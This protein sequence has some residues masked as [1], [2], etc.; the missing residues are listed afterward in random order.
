MILSITN[1]SIPENWRRP[2]LALA[3]ALVFLLGLY[4]DTVISITSIWWRS[5][6]YAHGLVIIPLT[7][8]MI[9]IRRQQVAHL[10]PV[11]SWWGVT[12]LLIAE[13]IW[14]LGTIVD[15][16]VVQQLALLGMIWAVIVGILGL[17]AVKSILFPLAYLFFAIPL[18]EGLIPSLMDITA[19]FTVKALVLTGFPVYW[20]GTSFSIPIGSFEV[21]KA[22]SG[23][24]YLF[25]SV[26]LGSLFAY[27]NF[28]SYKK[29]MIFILIS[30]VLPIVANGLRAYGIV[31]IANY[32]NMR[33]AVGLDHLI[34]G[35]LFFGLIMFLLFFFGAMWRDV[36]PSTNVV[37]ENPQLSIKSTKMTMLVPVFLLLLIAVG[38]L[39]RQSVESENFTPHRAELSLPQTMGQWQQVVNSPHLPWKIE[40]QGVTHQVRT[41]YSGQQQYIRFY[42]GYYANETQVTELINQANRFYDVKYWKE[43]QRREKVILLENK[44]KY[45]LY[46][47]ILK[48]GDQERILWYWYDLNGYTTAN[49][50]IG[51]FIQ[52]WLRLTG[53]DQGG[54]VVALVADVVDER[55]SAIRALKAFISDFSPVINTSLNEVRKG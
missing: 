55:E 45:V 23:I 52:A 11:A 4:N 49:I 21:A 18:G 48:R 7:L 51:K 32:S 8:Y 27:M 28:N 47:K 17:Q 46:E 1:P 39:G 53:N 29:R 15:V 20:E 35:W 19:Y 36:A 30:I 3:I 9:W 41:T 26:A 40:F 44:A 43:V 14:L 10:V 38:Q 22:C 13:F 31:L 37:T 5:E 54:A 42:L 2:L 6:T 50:Y 24:R 16:L 25:A 12:M 33:Y 34:Y